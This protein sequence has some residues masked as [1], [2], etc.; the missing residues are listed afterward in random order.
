MSLY[1]EL[2]NLK[3]EE[4]LFKFSQ[5]LIDMFGPLPPETQE[6]LQTM[7]LRWK[8]ADLYFEKIVLKKGSFTG[9]FI[10]NS[11]SPFYQSELF[12]K[13]LVFM[14]KN[15]PTVQIKEVNKKLLLTIKNIGIR[16]TAYGY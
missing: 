10:G 4:E 6:L 7:P 1:K 11:S 8:A 13:I 5:K 3:N 2:S 9:Y 12:S 15:H 16:S 14:Q